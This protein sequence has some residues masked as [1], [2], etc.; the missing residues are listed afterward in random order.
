MGAESGRTPLTL[1]KLHVGDTAF[2]I[3][4]TDNRMASS[5]DATKQERRRKTRVMAK[6]ADRRKRNKPVNGRR[7]EDVL[8]DHNIKFVPLAFEIGSAESGAWSKTLKKLSEI[9]HA[10]RGHDK[11]YFRSLWTTEIAMCLAKRGAQ[12]ALRNA[13][14]CLADANAALNIDE[15]AFGDAGVEIPLLVGGAGGG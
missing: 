10:R 5:N 14:L 6:L 8:R 7:L 13:H 9:A 12:E 4:V 3:V 11:D 2:D 15:G 1:G